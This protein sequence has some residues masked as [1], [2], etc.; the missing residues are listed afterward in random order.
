M[1]AEDNFKKKWMTH[2][3][4][5]DIAERENRLKKKIYSKKI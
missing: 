5:K 1:I 4:K 3:L 2:Y